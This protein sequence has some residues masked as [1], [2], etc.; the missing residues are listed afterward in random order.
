MLG[1]AVLTGIIGL[2]VVVVEV[3]KVLIGA[4]LAED[5]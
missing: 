3:E 4:Y 5:E 1:L 2:G